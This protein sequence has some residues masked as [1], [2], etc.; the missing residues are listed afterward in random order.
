MEQKLIDFFDNKKV[1][2]LGFGREG[3]STYD[4]LKSKVPSCNIT[5]ADAKEQMLSS[6]S[7][8]GC[9][10]YEPL[11]CKTVFGEGYMN[12]LS[13]YDIIMKAPGVPILKDYGKEIEDRITSQTDL[14]LRF[15]PS[16]VIGITGTKGKSTT[17]SLIYHILKNCGLKTRLVGNIGVPVFADLQNIKKDTVVVYELSCHQLQFVKA[18]PDISVLLN[19]FSDHLDHYR[20]FDEYRD[21]KYNIF[22]YQKPDD[23][24][25]VGADCENIDMKIFENAVQEVIPASDKAPCG[26]DGKNIFV[27][28]EIIPAERLKTSLIGKHNL[29]NISVA[30]T[31]IKDLVPDFEKALDT[32]KSFKGL[33][34]RLELFATIDGVRYFNDSIATIPEAAINAVKAIGD[35]KTLIVGGM[36]RGI[37]YSEFEKY[38]SEGHVENVIL[39]YESGKRI[40]NEIQP[41]SPKCNIF[42]VEDIYEAAD[43]AKEITKSGSVLFS[44]AAASYGYFKNFE[45]RG[46]K[47]KNYLLKGNQN[48]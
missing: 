36:D 10:S 11:D 6:V 28:D 25:I 40:Y 13:G 23:T 32:V 37:S 3:R 26:T 39:S 7:P 19:V 22:K 16:K 15:T 9:V 8:C 34:H 12:D 21:A 38:L 4:F 42:T 24:L 14:F 46:C 35:V 43:K 44:P 20:S 45:E 17:S 31:A 29:Y 1:L 41:L 2:I 33:E 30:L 5:V 47:F 48:V 27:K 18:S